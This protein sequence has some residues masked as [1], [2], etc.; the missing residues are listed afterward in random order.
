[1]GPG[2]KILK[3][4][5]KNFENSWAPGPAVPDPYPASR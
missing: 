1:V 5:A 4:F 3:I 2:P